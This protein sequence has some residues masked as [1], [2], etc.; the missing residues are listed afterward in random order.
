MR[1]VRIEVVRPPKGAIAKV[2]VLVVL[3]AQ[4][5][6]EDN[7]RTIEW[8]PLY[9]LLYRES[10]IAKDVIVCVITD[11]VFSGLDGADAAGAG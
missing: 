7:R 2:G 5:V 1:E 6:I 11:V 8:P 10:T 3:V 4:I 9:V